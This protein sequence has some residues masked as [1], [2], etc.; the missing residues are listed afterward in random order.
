M[1]AKVVKPKMKTPIS[2][3]GGKQSMLKHIL[4]MIP[5]HRVY[6]EP[7]FGGGAVY[8][9]KEPAKVEIINDHNAMVVNFFEQIKSNFDEL[10]KM[11]DA[12]PYSRTVYKKA[13]TIYEVPVIFSPKYRAWAFWVVTLQGFAN[14]IGSWH[15]SNKH[16]KEAGNI[17]N[18][19]LAFTR[20][21][22]DRMSRTQIEQKD[23][24]ALIKS[25][26]SPETFYYIDP[27]YVGAH[28]GHYGGYTQ[29]HFN[30][31]LDTL[32]KLKGKFILSSYPNPILD[33]YRREF[34]W[35]SND[36]KVRKSGKSKIE[37]L[38]INFKP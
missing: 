30:L 25:L 26:D 33:K 7:F 21:L 27:P 8:F 3:Y 2:Y 6:V 32:S 18:R 23:A 24:V 36:I 10:K 9:A 31:L 5:E 20:E 37:A 13:M 38:T 19:R 4:P 29:E 15:S 17:A 35:Y 16:G 12:T 28:Q 22:A 1:E 11:I 14:Q 34:V